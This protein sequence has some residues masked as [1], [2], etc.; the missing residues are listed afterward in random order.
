MF[1]N[2]IDY[3]CQIIISIPIQ[4]KK[5]YYFM[6]NIE[7]MFLSVCVNVQSA[8]IYLHFT[9]SIISAFERSEKN[10]NYVL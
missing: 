4:Y 2:S 8:L 1:N 10:D 9:L 3:V 6:M 5:K 7:Y